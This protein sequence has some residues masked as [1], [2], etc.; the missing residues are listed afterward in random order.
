MYTV[1][2][3]DRAMHSYSIRFLVIKAQSCSSVCYGQLTGVSSENVNHA[4]HDMT[5][6]P[7]NKLLLT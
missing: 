2:L 4:T 7:N 5:S 3:D 6:L 1:V